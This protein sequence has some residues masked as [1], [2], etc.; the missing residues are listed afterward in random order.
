MDVI[1]KWTLAI[2]LLDTD[3]SVSHNN[4]N[5]FA[6]ISLM[7]SRTIYF[8]DANDCNWTQKAFQTL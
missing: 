7:T 8:V 3:E 6:Q 4:I 2:I 1:S 5:K